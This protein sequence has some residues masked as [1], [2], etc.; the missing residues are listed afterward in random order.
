MTDPLTKPLLKP[1]DKVHFID[2]H[3]PAIGSGDYRVTVTQD[4]PALEFSATRSIELAVKGPRFTLLPSEVASSFPPKGATGAFD[5]VLPH[6]LINRSTLPWERTAVAGQVVPWLALL[7]CSEDELA[8]HT[9]VVSAASLVTDDVDGDPAAPAGASFAQLSRE[10]ADDLNAQVLVLDLPADLAQGLLPTPDDLALLAGVREV[11]GHPTRAILM[12]NRLPVPGKRNV[13]HLVS[14]EHQFAANGAHWSTTGQRPPSVRFVS[15][16]NWDFVCDPLPSAPEAAAGSFADLITAMTNGPFTLS[17]KDLNTTATKVQNGFVPI[18]QHLRDGQTSAAWYR[19]PLRAVPQ[20]EP[21]ELPVRRPE[22]LLQ[23]DAD[24][25]MFDVSY[26]AAWQLGLTLALSNP[27]VSQDI[28]RWKRA[29]AHREH[30]VAQSMSHP[31]HAIEVPDTPEFPAKSWF[32]NALARLE[33]VPFTHLVPEEKLLPPETLVGFTIDPHWIAALY[34]GAFSI[35]RTSQR[36]LQNDRWSRRLLPEPDAVSGVLI[37]SRIVSGWP[38]LQIDPTANP[39]SEDPDERPGILRQDKLGRE[40]LLVLF[41]DHISSVTLHLHPQA[42][43]FGVDRS[44]GKYFKGGQSL[45][46]R[47][48]PGVV[49]I[50]ALSTSLGATSPHAFAFEMVEGSPQ[51]IFQFGGMA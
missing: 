8:G 3:V 36:E 38:D 41:D 7:V 2:S 11:Q 23:Y 25:G 9:Q 24:S 6:V 5:N 20:S 4:V 46:F 28:H 12:A 42:I 32:L 43:H 15:L 44:H 10:R 27:T 47:T 30:A 21:E 14:L 50:T 48:T 19:G 18:R 35:G 34:D 39:P 22:E 45:A 13:V 1:H 37:R 51:S 33:E 31:D 16:M 26:A 49:D 29:I 17:N 40:V